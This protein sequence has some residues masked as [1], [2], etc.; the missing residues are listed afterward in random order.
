MAERFFGPAEVPN[1]EAQFNGSTIYPE[2]YSIDRLL[3]CQRY[4]GRMVAC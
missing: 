4:E 2:K 1:V 3:E